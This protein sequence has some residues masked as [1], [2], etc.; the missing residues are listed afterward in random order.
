MKGV[1][2]PQTRLCSATAKANTSRSQP[3]PVLIGAI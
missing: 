1:E 2:M 3:S